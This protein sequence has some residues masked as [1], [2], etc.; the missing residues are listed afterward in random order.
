MGIEKSGSLV[1]GS[2]SCSTVKLVSV[3]DYVP[4]IL[5]K[6]VWYFYRNISKYSIYGNTLKYSI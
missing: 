4:F 1:K 3:L 5:D 2:I 6:Y